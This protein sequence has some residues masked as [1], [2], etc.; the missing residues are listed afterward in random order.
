MSDTLQEA[1]PSGARGD[2]EPVVV[3]AHPSLGQQSSSGAGVPVLPVG[4]FSSS[5][6][7]AW[8]VPFTAAARAFA[9]SVLA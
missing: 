3:A 2:R 7:E 1:L 6:A 9:P 5:A 8:E 4:T